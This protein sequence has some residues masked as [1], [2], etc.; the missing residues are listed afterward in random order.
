VRNIVFTCFVTLFCIKLVWANSEYYKSNEFRRNQSLLASQCGYEF[1]RNF[2]WRITKSSSKLGDK[3][4]SIDF[5]VD[6]M[7][8]HRNIRGRLS[9]SCLMARSDV[10][11]KNSVQK[12]TAADEIALE[13]SGG[14]YAR[15]IVWQR[16]YEGVGWTGTIAYVNS[17]FGDQEKQ[18][19]PEYFL[20][21]PD[22]GGVGCF[23]FEIEGLKLE[24]RESDQIPV[25]L[26]GVLMINSRNAVSNSSGK[27]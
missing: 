3:F 12:T 27:Q 11:L 23:S 19:I 15:G 5:Y 8:A 10:S 13:D 6:L 25:L 7:P 20:I 1:D 2:P 22:E 9:F 14:R 16:R 17:I 24:K 21:C 26:H 4:V 18:K